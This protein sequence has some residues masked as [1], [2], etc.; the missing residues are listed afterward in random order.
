MKIFLMIAMLVG[1]ACAGLRTDTLTV[2]GGVKAARVTTTGVARLDSVS[3]TKGI[4]APRGDYSG[5]VNVDTL[6]STK[7]ISA[8]KGN[9][10]SSVTADSLFIRDY[11]AYYSSTNKLCSLYNGSTYRNRKTF[12]YTVSFRIVNVRIT[13][14][15]TGDLTSGATY[16]YLHDILSQFRPE[17]QNV[18]VQIITNGAFQ[19]GVLHLSNTA[20]CKL[21]RLG[22]DDISAVGSS[23]ISEMS[24]SYILY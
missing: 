2:T 19:T 11:P 8:T 10:S 16:L 20:T 21:T 18:L 7:G 3:V 4:K 6:H 22:D 12:F 5:T 13:D 17:T 1:V 24:F 15:L 23:G 9:F 14:S